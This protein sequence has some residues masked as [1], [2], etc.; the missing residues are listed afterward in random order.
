MREVFHAVT[1]SFVSPVPWS[2][3]WMNHRG[4][5]SSSERMISTGS[6]TVDC[7][8][9]PDDPRSSTPPKAYKLATASPA[10]NVRQRLA[11]LSPCFGSGLLDNGLESTDTGQTVIR[12]REQTCELVAARLPRPLRGVL[13]WKRRADRLV[14]SWACQEPPLQNARLQVLQCTLP[15][16]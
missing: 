1:E 7:G 4:Q 2:C 8:I 10:G 11:A 16:P 14:R 9:S 5:D 15:I 12:I 6:S 13:A 3:R